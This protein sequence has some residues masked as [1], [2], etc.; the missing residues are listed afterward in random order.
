MILVELKSCVTNP[1]HVKMMLFCNPEVNF[2]VIALNHQA[3]YMKAKGCVHL[4]RF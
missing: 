1:L 4:D 2:H 3:D